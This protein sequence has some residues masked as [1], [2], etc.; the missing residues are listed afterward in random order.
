MSLQQTHQ[1]LLSQTQAVS[2]VELELQTKAE[3]YQVSIRVL[4]QAELF[5]LFTHT[6]AKLTTFGEMFFHYYYAL[7]LLHYII[8]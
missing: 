8:Y 6:N 7:C 5:F 1:L 2:R 4:A 3:Q